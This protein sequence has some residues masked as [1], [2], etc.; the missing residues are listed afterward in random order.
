L[1]ATNALRWNAGE[2]AEHD[3]RHG[4]G[5]NHDAAAMGQQIDASLSKSRRSQP[6]FTLPYSSSTMGV[7][8]DQTAIIIGLCSTVAACS[9]C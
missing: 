1:A 2:T 6:R 9:A 4:G 7:Q 3:A 5:G 8:R